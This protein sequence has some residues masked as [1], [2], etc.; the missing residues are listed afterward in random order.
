VETIERSRPVVLVEVRDRNLEFV[1]EFLAS[2][3]YRGRRL[4]ELV[5]VRGSRENRIYIP[6]E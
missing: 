3:G 5:G 2:R 1:E 6:A 4:E